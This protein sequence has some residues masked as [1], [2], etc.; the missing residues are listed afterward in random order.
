MKIKLLLIAIIIT[1]FGWGQCNIYDATDCVCEDSS[2]IDCDLLSDI[3]VSWYGI[4]TYSN[5]P[6]EYPQSGA[7]ENNGRLRISVSTPNTGYG[8][9][10]VRGVDDNGYAYFVCDD[11]TIAVQ[12]GGS[13]GGYYC[14]DSDEPAKHLAI[15][16]IYHRNADGSMGYWDRFA[17]TMTYHPTHGHMHSD[18]WGVLHLE[19][20]IQMIQIL[21]IGQ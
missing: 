5:G 13:I 2:E 10:T 9:L 4:L 20:R 17:G 6:S 19:N 11:D 8:P 7:G 21:L 1:S 3:Q 12:T 15:Q 14:D 16:R 18:E